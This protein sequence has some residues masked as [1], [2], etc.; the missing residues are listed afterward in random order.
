M[1]DKQKWV[2]APDDA[3]IEIA[4]GKNARVSP[5][6]KDALDKLA[7]A[8]EAEQEVQGY[9][10]CDDVSISQD[11]NWYMSCRGVTG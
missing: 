9:S 2:V 5:E 4:I 10:K 7:Q 11:C 8:L 6:V 1:A 3:R